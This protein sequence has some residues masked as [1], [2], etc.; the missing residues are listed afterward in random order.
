[1]SNF[2]SLYFGIGVLVIVVY[3][4]PQF[5]KPSFQTEATL[6]RT[7]D[8]LR[9]LF[10]KSS[11]ARARFTYVAISILLYF[12]LVS[13]GPPLAPIVNVKYD[14]ATWP[15][16]ISL[17][18]VG[19]MPN[20]KWLTAIEEFV[21]RTVHAW[22]LVPEGVL[23]TIA[24]LEDT[25][26]EPSQDQLEAVTNPA[27][28]SK[29]CKELRLPVST[30]QYRWARASMLMTSLQQM[31]APLR[32]TAFDPFELDF[33]EIRTSYRALKQQIEQF[34]NGSVVDTE[35]EDTLIQQIDKLLKRIYAY[36]SWGVR[37]Q[38]DTEHDVD[39]I[40][41]E[42]G[43]RIPP[44]GGLRL[45]DIVALPVVLVLAIITAFWVVFQFYFQWGPPAEAEKIL[46]AFSAGI[47]G[48]VMYGIGVRIAL[49]QRSTQIDQGRWLEGSA[50]CLFPIALRA[51]LVAWAVIAVTSILTDMIYQPDR[52]TGSVTALI[53][54]IE[55]SAGDV[56]QLLFFTRPNHFGRAVD[57]RW[58]NAQRWARDNGGEKHRWRTDKTENPGRG[59][60]G[61][62]VGLW[63]SGL[64]N[65]AK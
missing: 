57:H 43:F 60:F 32:R 63:C 17:V 19:V 52:V 12:V 30:L 44:T 59:S 10:L 47:T 53:Q 49:K 7:V 15:L 35:G 64:A 33:E 3:A 56:G 16:L 25:N 45:F 4:W 38:A 61:G 28:R 37:Y 46:W 6:P 22:F 27:L 24:V 13:A 14:P 11:Y 26:Y 1:M 36:I 42:L 8:P 31:R 48:A 34:Q 23:G 54:A 58:R 50:T 18:L 21:R 51:G 9:Y 20:L 2:S 29:V 39:D 40:L 41:T 5:N 62:R 65:P 55:G